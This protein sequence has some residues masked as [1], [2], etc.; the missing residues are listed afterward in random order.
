MRGRIQQEFEDG[1]EERCFSII[2]NK[3]LG[4]TVQ[5]HPIFEYD[6]FDCD[7]L[8]PDQFEDTTDDDDH[9]IRIMDE[10]ETMCSDHKANI[11]I[12][13]FRNAIADQETDDGP[14]FRCT[15]CA[16][17][18]T[19]KISSKQ[20]TISLQEAREQEFI[21]KSVNLD[22]KNR[23]VVVNYPFL[24]EPIQFLLKRHHDEAITLKLCMSI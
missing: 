4:T 21:E 5:P 19:C 12:A 13:K 7:K 15:E 11:P 6:V 8:I 3:F 1:F 20:Q 24:K 18:V 17:C 16:K 2:T 9:L 23:R 14:G 10:S 22:I